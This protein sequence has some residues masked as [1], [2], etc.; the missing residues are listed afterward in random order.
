MKY[1]TLIN[2]QM[3]LLLM[4]IF[5][6]SRGEHI[7]VNRPVIEQL[8]ICWLI[9]L[10]IKNPHKKYFKK[11]CAVSG[12]SNNDLL[13]PDN[14]FLNFPRILCL[15][16]CILV[17]LVIFV[18]NNFWQHIL[19]IIQNFQANFDDQDREKI[20]KKMV[21]VIDLMN[22]ATKKIILKPVA[23]IDSQ[24]KIVPQTRLYSTKKK[25]KCRDP[26]IPKPTIN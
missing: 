22:A 4:P 10:I 7:R 11:S 18:V 19:P 3:C 16:L 23:N 5:N 24:Q 17:A 13:T 21:E 25:R 20:E 8:I 14:L 12:C 9:V 2:G 26:S 1:D 6:K 15:I